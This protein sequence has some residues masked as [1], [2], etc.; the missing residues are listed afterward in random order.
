MKQMDLAIGMERTLGDWFMV[1]ILVQSIAQMENLW[2]HISDI[3]AKIKD[4]RQASKYF[5]NV[6]NMEKLVECLYALEDEEELGEAMNELFDDYKL[7]PSTRDKILRIGICEHIV[8]SFIKGGDVKIAFESY[9]ELNNCSLQQAWDI[10]YRTIYN[11]TIGV[12][13][14][15]R[16]FIIEFPD[17]GPSFNSAPEVP[18]GNMMFKFAKFIPPRRLSLRET[19][20]NILQPHL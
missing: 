4:W 19:H 16:D 1:E 8:T 14:Y 18:K 6:K 5:M 20:F 3:L 17:V 12:A 9:I 10:L 7:L 15:N 2:N 13:G 11:C